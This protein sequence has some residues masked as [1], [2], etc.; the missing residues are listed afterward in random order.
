MTKRELQYKEIFFFQRSGQ[1]IIDNISD[2]NIFGIRFING[3]YID[4]MERLRN[5]GFMVVPSA[6][7]L[8]T[9]GSDLQY[10]KAVQNSDFA[11]PDSGF[12][13]LL[14][15][16][17]KG[18]RIRKL[19]GAMFIKLFVNEPFLK[20]KNKI[21]LV[22]PNIEESK[23]NHNYLNG[24]GIPLSRKN[25]Y[26]APIY[27]KTAIVD[28]QLLYI[29]ENLK[30][31]PKFILINLGSGVQERLGYYLK[32]YLSFTT[33]IICSGAA[34]AFL[35]GAQAKM[36][37][38]VEKIYCGWLCRIIQN[39]KQY[40]MRYIKAFKLIYIFYLEKRGVFL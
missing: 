26:I 19:S 28:T 21:F 35:T 1:L 32:N 27:D 31:K 34:I 30:E 10:T 33:G 13:V 18:K 4:A 9:L 17:F 16:I 6:P 2:Y 22:D 39:P 24:V 37:N 25:Q 12:M 5:G 3:S 40:T 20:D 15:R 7:G 23:L 11:I 29:L 36:P 8:A 38:W 14:Y